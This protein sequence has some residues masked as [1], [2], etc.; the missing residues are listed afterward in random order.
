[1]ILLPKIRPERESTLK[2]HGF[3]RVLAYQSLFRLYARMRVVGRVLAPRF[4]VFLSQLL[5]E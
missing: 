5:V 3:S 2:A 1:M 4:P